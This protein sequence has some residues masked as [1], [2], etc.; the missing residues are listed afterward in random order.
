MQVPT[1]AKTLRWGLLTTMLPNSGTQ[2]NLSL[3]GLRGLAVLLVLLYHHALLKLGWLGVD[4]FFVLSGFLITG[5]LRRSRNDKSYWAGFWIK[6]VTR[7]LPPFLVVLCA[8]TA[9]GYAPAKLFFLYLATLGDVVAVLHPSVLTVRPLWSLAIE[10]HFYFLWPFAV[11]YLARRSL[12]R[13]LSV[14]LVLEPALRFA[15]S[16]FG[17]VGRDVIYFLTPFRLDGLVLGSL[18]A[19]LL[20]SQQAKQ[21]LQQVSPVLCAATALL[22]VAFCAVLRISFTP[23]GTSP[24]YNA[25]SYLLVALT[26]FWLISSLLLHPEGVGTRIFAWRP[27]AWVGRI[28]YGVYLYQV[29][30]LYFVTSFTHARMKRAIVVTGPLTLLVAW[31]SFRYMEEPLILWGKRKAR[32]YSERSGKTEFASPSTAP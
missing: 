28:S 32:Q 5:V 16:Y 3:D 23:G 14:L 22:Y 31:I 11:R 20:E 18:L 17:H 6:R 4:L 10:E 29:F 1:L 26:V 13:T 7:I 30:I 21:K 15:T 19:L 27:L 25:L 24:S 12:I 2:R 9:L 8:A